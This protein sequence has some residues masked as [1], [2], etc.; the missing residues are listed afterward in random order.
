MWKEGGV[1]SRLGGIMQCLQ[2][3]SRELFTHSIFVDHLAVHK[4]L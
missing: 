2:M 4:L 3:S 1:E